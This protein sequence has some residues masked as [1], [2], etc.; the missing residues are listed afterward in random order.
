MLYYQETQLPSHSL[1]GPAV[2]TTP[3]MDESM[4]AMPT[5]MP[6][7]TAT[8]SSS[9][10]FSPSSAPSTPPG[11]HQRLME[12]T[13]TP[14]GESELATPTAAAHQ[15]MLG[16]RIQSTDEAN[17]PFA[18]F[19]NFSLS[20]PSPTRSTGLSAASTRAAGGG[21]TSISGPSSHALSTSVTMP[22]YTISPRQGSTDVLSSARGSITSTG[23]GHARHHSHSTSFLPPSNARESAN[24]PVHRLGSKASSG[25]IHRL[26]FP[27][28]GSSSRLVGRDGGSNGD[29][30]LTGRGGPDGPTAPAG[31]S[32]A[33]VG[34]GG[35]TGGGSQPIEGS[36]DSYFRRLSTLPASTIPAHMPPSL[37]RLIDS[38]RGLLFGL[39]Q[40][41]STLR[42]NPT[43]PLDERFAGVL[44]RVLTPAA[45]ATDGL[46]NALDRFDSTSRRAS[47]PPARVVRGVVEALKA[48]VGAYGKVVAVLIIQLKL[49]SSKLVHSTSTLSVSSASAPT[50]S[51]RENF[52]DIR[53]TRTL[54][55]NL[56]GAMGEISLG[57]K[58]MLPILPEIS[59]LLR[60][61]N[62]PPRHPLTTP[63]STPQGRQQRLLSTTSSSRLVMSPVPE[64][65][66]QSGSGTSP[67]VQSGAGGTGLEGLSPGTTPFPP[68]SNSVVPPPP[69]PSA[70]SAQP[71]GP[72]TNGTANHQRT[73]SRTL[74]STQSHTTHLHPR[75]DDRRP[76]PPFPAPPLSSTTPTSGVF[77]QRPVDAQ[78]ADSPEAPDLAGQLLEEAVQT[79]FAVWNLMEND[80]QWNPVRPFLF[81]TPSLARSTMRHS[82]EGRLTF[83]SRLLVFTQSSNDHHG[84][85]PTSAA[86]SQPIIDLLSLI[87]LARTHTRDLHAVLRSSSTSTVEDDPA[88][89]ER[90]TAFFQSVRQVGVRTKAVFESERR[91]FRR[92]LKVGLG[93]LTRLTMERY[94]FPIRSP[95]SLPLGPS[96]REV[97]RRLI[98]PFQSLDTLLLSNPSATLLHVS[99]LKRPGTSMST[100]T[101]FQP[102]DSQPSF[103]SSTSTSLHPLTPPSTGGTGGGI[104]PLIMGRSRSATGGALMTPT[105]AEPMPPSR[106]AGAGGGGFVKGHGG[107]KPGGRSVGG[108]TGGWEK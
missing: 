76:P 84:S 41:Q 99:N 51:H 101:S 53:F 44:S 96:S 107:G 74:S 10:G 58:S 75:E 18:Q 1:R 29:G 21:G 9:S 87:S 65:I 94:V 23:S 56:Y 27:Q 100:Y 81:F 52:E 4:T 93:K 39:A 15:P 98:K 17:T 38:A 32:T 42:R 2:M 106:S 64:R 69:T 91:E 86:L 103:A 25:S 55:L 11:A 19:S 34:G 40:I 30:G 54:L 89:I 70:P 31:R 24:P 36:R 82:Q 46:I 20:A 108:S 48:N 26:A 83:E 7:S 33:Q 35:P 79:G 88:L 105:R 80:L 37:L 72:A 14:D 45:V 13:D 104:R 57:W 16:A 61:P 92:D 47:Q 3:P 85:R 66:E 28:S 62:A 63:T 71:N 68:S 97:G 67:S 12:G 90:A 59:P 8:F 43:S 95:S 78:G 102:D 6:P 77:G 60:D 5:V 50:A 22:L 73:H 49:S